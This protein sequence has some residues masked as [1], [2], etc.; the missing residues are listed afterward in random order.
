VKPARLLK[1]GRALAV[2]SFALAF[3]DAAL[4]TMLGLAKKS[5]R[6][7]MILERNIPA[8]M[9]DGVR[10]FANLFRPPAGGP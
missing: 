4:G 6:T 9:R 2:S 5:H 7:S 1:F 8:P 10:L 3:A